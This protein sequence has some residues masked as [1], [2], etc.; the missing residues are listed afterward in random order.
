MFTNANK[1]RLTTIKFINLEE[2]DDLLS[3]YFPLMAIDY[4]PVGKGNDLVITLGH[5]SIEATPY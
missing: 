4:Y 1:G 3:E 2:S 5:D